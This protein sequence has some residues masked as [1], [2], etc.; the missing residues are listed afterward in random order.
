MKGRPKGEK[1]KRL[2]SEDHCLLCGREKRSLSDME[3]KVVG[4]QED[5][6]S[7]PGDR[8]KC[9]GQAVGPGEAGPHTFVT[10]VTLTRSKGFTSSTVQLSD[11]GREEN[12]C[13]SRC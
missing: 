3:R 10:E 11:T 13:L 4:H 5:E 12:G 8:G 6:K 7:G 1:R 2:L 9:L